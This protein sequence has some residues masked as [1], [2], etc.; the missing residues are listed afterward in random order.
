MSPVPLYRRHG[1][2]LHQYPSCPMCLGQRPW[3]SSA[4][5]VRGC[6]FKPPTSD[7]ALYFSVKSYREPMQIEKHALIARLGIPYRDMRQMDPFT[8]QPYPAAI[9]VREKAIV[10]S[11]ES[12]RLITAKVRRLRSCASRRQIGYSAGNM[13]GNVRQ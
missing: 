9:L 5:R 11:L 6:S 8:A 3:Y 2:A 1:I 10:L 12:I 4:W 13:C 7:R